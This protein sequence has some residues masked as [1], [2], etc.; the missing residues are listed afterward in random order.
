MR[1]VPQEDLFLADHADLHSNFELVVRQ[2]NI[3]LG[4]CLPDNNVTKVRGAANNALHRVFEQL[5]E[6]LEKLTAE[7]IWRCKMKLGHPGGLWCSRL[8]RSSEQHTK[9][10]LP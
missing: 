1:H 10:A 3:F 8:D 7:I 6:Q 2:L 9:Y 4:L 5:L